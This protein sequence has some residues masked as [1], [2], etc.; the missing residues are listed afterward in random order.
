MA[1]LEELTGFLSTNCELEPTTP[2]D[3]CCPRL[4]E[5]RKRI[6]VAHR[7]FSMLVRLA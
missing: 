5:G 2:P 7:G 4:Q 1:R 3:R 6:D